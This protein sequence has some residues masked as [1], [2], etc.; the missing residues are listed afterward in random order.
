[1]DTLVRMCAE[2]GVAR[3]VPLMTRRSVVK[4]S[5]EDSAHKLD[6]LRKIC[7]S[8]SEQ[9]GRSIVTAIAPPATLEEL[10]A[11]RDPSELGVLL[12]ADASAPTLPHLLRDFAGGPLLILV[13]PEGDFTPEEKEL[14]LSRGLRAARL[15]ESILRVET[16]AIAAAAI[17]MTADS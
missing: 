9:S 8:A 4:L 5:A 7:V 10:L 3:I 2:L 6:R 15:T 13:G 17:A 14:A 1:M 11:S 12:S 16:A